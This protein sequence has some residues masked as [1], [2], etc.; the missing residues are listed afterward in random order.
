MN[1][2][3]KLCNLCLLEEGT[4]KLKIEEYQKL[5]RIK[6]SIKEVMKDQSDQ[7]VEKWL[8]GRKRQ[9]KSAEQKEMKCSNIIY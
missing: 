4:I 9:G 6:F 5:E 8:R 7:K 1:E 2:D 3:G